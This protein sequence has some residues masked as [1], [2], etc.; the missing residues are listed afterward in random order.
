MERSNDS[1]NTEQN[2]LESNSESVGLEKNEDI[3]YNLTNALVYC[4]Y[5]LEVENL[6]TNVPTQILTA[7]I[8]MG[9]EIFKKIR[10]MLKNRKIVTDEDLIC[11]RYKLMG[12]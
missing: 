8:A 1:E 7:F 5:F 10:F 3:K 9:E 6:L 12:G 4:K 11:Q 2:I